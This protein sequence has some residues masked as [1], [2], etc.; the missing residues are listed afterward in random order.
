M[1]SKEGEPIPIDS[2]KSKLKDHVLGQDPTMAVR[3]KLNATLDE[4][5]S[6]K[7]EIRSM[8]K[9]NDQ[10]L[11]KAYQGIKSIEEIIEDTLPQLSEVINH[12]KEKLDAI[13][14]EM[15]SSMYSKVSEIQVQNDEI[16]ELV[17][18][19]IEE[20]KHEIKVLP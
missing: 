7:R 20:I 15:L 17:K 2:L 1:Q 9:E 5:N 13:D 12:I 19:G 18:S 8:N 6:L 3:Q 10:T 4:L 16:K 14:P 11:N